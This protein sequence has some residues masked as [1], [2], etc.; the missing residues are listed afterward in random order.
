MP[1]LPKDVQ[2]TNVILKFEQVFGSLSGTAHAEMPLGLRNNADVPLNLS[3]VVL[4]AN[5]AQSSS[6]WLRQIPTDLRRVSTGLLLP[7]S[8]LSEERKAN[9]WSN[10]AIEFR[11][12]DQVRDRVSNPAG[13]IVF[14]VT[15]PAGS[16]SQLLASKVD[17]NIP[18]LT[19]TLVIVY[20]EPPMMPPW[21]KK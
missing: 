12:T 1:E 4:G 6:V 15:T 11:V 17:L 2:I 13:E 3:A 19:A 5:D 10:Q 8:L 18:K 7:A 16:S 20:S 14:V 21:H 9:R